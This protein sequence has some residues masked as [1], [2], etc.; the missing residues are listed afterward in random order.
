ME[1]DTADLSRKVR[2]LAN[3]ADRMTAH[4]WY[5]WLQDQERI[6]FDEYRRRPNRLVSD[7]KGESHFIR[8][9]EGRE[10]LELL[11]NANDAALK[12]DQRGRTHFELHPAGLIAAN[13]GASF[14]P[15]G[16]ESLCLPHTSPKRAEGPQMIGNKGL[17]F[18]AVLNWTRFPLILSGELAIVFSMRVAEDI[19]GKLALLSE[20]LRVCIEREKQLSGDR[21]VPLLAFPGFSPD[22]DLTHFLDEKQNTIYS[23]CRELQEAG[24]DTVIGMPFDEAESVRA[25][26]EKQVRFLRPEV[27]LFAS[28]LAELEI[29]I[30]GELPACW[31]RPEPV[32]VTSRVYLG[33]D[34]KDYREWRLFPKRGT[35]P[36]EHLP[37]EQPSSTEY[38]VVLAI[39]T[40]HKAVFGY[41]YSYFPTEVRFPYPAVCHVT[42][43]LITNR[44]QPQNTLAN[45]FIIGELAG[46]MAQTAEALAHEVAPECGLELIAGDFST[47]DGLEK[48]EF[49]SHLLEAAKKRA[50]VPTLANGLVLAGEARRVAYSDITWMPKTAFPRVVNLANLQSLQPLLEKLDVPPLSASD[51]EFA[52]RHLKLEALE[53]RADFISGVIR[54]Q[55][56]EAFDINGLLLDGDGKPVPKGYRVFFPPTAQPGL[57]VPNWFEIRFLNQGLRQALADKLKPK[58]QEGLAS[59][60]SP[61]GVTRYSLDNVLG[62]LVAQAN[63]SAEAEPDQN[64]RIRRELVQALC[65]LFPFGEPTEER[66]RFPKDALVLILT[67]AGTYEDARK[68]YLSGEYG[69]RGRILEDLYGSFAPEKLV[70]PPSALGLSEAPFAFADFFQWIGVAQFPREILVTSP[71]RNF[72]NYLKANMSEPVVMQGYGGPD[73]Y[74]AHAGDMPAWLEYEGLASIDHLEKVLSQAPAA[75]VLAWLATDNRAL[76]WKTSSATH[77]KVGCRR[78]RD[79]NVRYFNG[80]IPSYV[81]WRLQTT[82]WLPTRNGRLVA[83]QECLAEAVQ[84]I[85][86]VLPQ[87]ARP[88]PEQAQ[89]YAVPISLFRDAFDRAGV[90]PGLSQIDPEQLYALLL[91]LPNRDQTGSVAKSVYNAVLKHFEGVDVRDSTARERFVRSGKMLARSPMGDNYLPI[92][93]VRHID[94]EDIPAA[95]RRRVN[96]AALPKRSGAQKVRALFGVRAVE[97]SEIIQRITRYQTASDAPVVDDELQR[98]KPLFFYLRSSQSRRARETDEFTHLKI[99][100]CSSIE[101]EVEFQGQKESLE[102]GSWDW[103]LDDQSHTAYVLRDPAES[104]LSRSALLADVVGQILAAI[105]RIERGD[106]FARLFACQRKDQLKMLKRLVGDD[107]V[108]AIEELERRYFDT[109]EQGNDSEVNFPDGALDQ[110]SRPMQDVTQPRVPEDQGTE[111]SPSRDGDKPLQIDSVPHIPSGPPVRV[112]C[113]VSRQGPAGPRKRTGSRRITD[114]LFCEYKAI[115]FEEH[116][117]PPRFPVRVGNITGWDAPGV[118]VLSF[119]SAEDRATFLAGDHSETRIARFIEV[120]GRSSEGAKIDLRDNALDA[121]RK[122]KD[123]YF[124]YRV[125]DRSDGSYALAALKNPLADETGTKVFCEVNLDAAT[126]TEEFAIVGGCSENSYLEHLAEKQSETIP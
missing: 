4:D 122:Y 110:P 69:S 109:A 20:E 39:P 113:R 111:S 104:D 94:S 34:D 82:K 49:R 117:A 6:K 103:I 126:R 120:K 98:L 102:L 33:A 92:E 73:Y 107:D 83:P 124:L 66:P 18:R 74:F 19:Q 100:V 77:G 3:G 97:R 125:Y 53:D 25:A 15:A 91:S 68:L 123:K 58:D 41:L 28:S 95:L 54:H 29:V 75:A 45:Q 89:R 22:G 40:N 10:I 44:Q 108:P 76:G 35:V 115:E 38:E 65:S 121:A 61:L 48:F 8:D 105:F 93:E 87:P 26:V 2:S 31:R 90:L 57:S 79:F 88:S 51:W 63:R 119:A 23:R 60:L 59:L 13:T 84:G 42:L 116:D 36:R 17:G 86:D 47:S 85:E 55:V 64:E 80:P 81:R 5:L 50:I 99:I 62:A 101:G 30:D 32:G 112:Q 56:K 43:D 14:S 37:P 52:E 71:D 11:Q 16:V 27:L 70:S 118:D 67:K 9:Y 7:F 1:I 24:Y 114:G 21:V 78:G 46:F 72:D 106:D 96:V 12:A